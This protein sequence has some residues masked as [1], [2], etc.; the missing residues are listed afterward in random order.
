MDYLSKHI[1]IKLQFK[2][3]LSGGTI[4]MLGEVYLP[5]FIHL[6]CHCKL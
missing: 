6:V 4:N 3:V 2:L 5:Y 1:M